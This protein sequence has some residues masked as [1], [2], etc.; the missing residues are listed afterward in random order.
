M[1]RATFLQSEESVIEVHG[2]A[3]LD[4]SWIGIGHHSRSSACM[5]HAMGRVGRLRD[6]TGDGG[7]QGENM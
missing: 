1:M 2:V 5:R 6:D 7:F 4:P 3:R